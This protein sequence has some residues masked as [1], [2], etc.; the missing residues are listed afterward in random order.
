MEKGNMRAEDLAGGAP[1]QDGHWGRTKGSDTRQR[2]AKWGGRM[3]EA[4]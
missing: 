2:S 4:S 3:V 1:Q